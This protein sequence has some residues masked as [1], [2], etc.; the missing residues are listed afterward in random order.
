MNG[1]A[2]D[3]DGKRVAIA[4]FTGAGGHAAVQVEISQDGQQF[5]SPVRVDLGNPVGRTQILLQPSGGATVFWLEN[6]SGSTQ[7]LVRNVSLTG[8]LAEP[9][10][11]A[12]GNGLGYPKVARTA[13]GAFDHVDRGNDGCKGSCSKLRRRGEFQVNPCLKGQAQQADRHLLFVLLSLLR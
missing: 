11:I 13:H 9:V 7:L 3:S 10:E 6:Q 8:K 5:S 1:P 4:W 2:L 12:R